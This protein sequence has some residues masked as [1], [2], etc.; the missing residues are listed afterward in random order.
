MDVVFSQRARSDLIAIGEYVAVQDQKAAL[1]LVHTIIDTL[2]VQ[3][4]SH[5][6][7]GRPGR[8]D[9]TRELVVHA[10]YIAAYRIRNGIVEVLTIRHTARLWPKSL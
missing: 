8:V 9:D 6:K 1:Q 4:A 5:P 7:S 3:L 2:L 10:S